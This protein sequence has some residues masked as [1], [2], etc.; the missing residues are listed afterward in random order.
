MICLQLMIPFAGNIVRCK[1][2]F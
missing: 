2:R 1:N